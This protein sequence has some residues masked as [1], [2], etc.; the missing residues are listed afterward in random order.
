MAQINP[1]AVSIGAAGPEFDQ[2]IDLTNNHWTVGADQ[3][4]DRFSL[5]ACV[6]LND[7]HAL[8]AGVPS[9]AQDFLET[10]YDAPD[11][12]DGPILVIGPGTG[13][14]QAIALEQDGETHVIATEGGHVTFPPR[15]EHEFNIM[16]VLAR[17]FGRV[18]IERIL[19]GAGILD[20]YRAHCELS[21]A[22]PV[23][24]TAAEVTIALDADETA[25]ATMAMFFSVLGRAVGDAALSTGAR[26]GVVLAGGI[27][28]KVKE[29]FLES[30]F[31]NE[32]LDKG[33]WRAYVEAIPVHMITKDGAGLHGAAAAL[34]EK[35]DGDY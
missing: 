12:P 31:L 32:Y 17:R 2:Y 28:P 27:L 7:F 18:S 26:G 6:V 10:V 3:L 1:R 9:L 29:R 25:M 15:S 13:L 35:F 21:G 8:A 23:F 24:E 19:S 20:L 16:Q 22:H 30:D 4:S 14:G 34:K 33:R 5:D 11:A